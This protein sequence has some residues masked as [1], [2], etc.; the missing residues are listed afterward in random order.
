MKGNMKTAVMTDIGRV[1]LTGGKG[2]DLA[3][4]TAGSQ[5]TAN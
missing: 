2:A 3:I 1:E 5:I 4:E